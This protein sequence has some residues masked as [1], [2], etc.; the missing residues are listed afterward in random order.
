MKWLA[1]LFRFGPSSDEPAAPGKSPHYAD[2][3]Q[4]PRTR[5]QIAVVHIKTGNALLGEGRFDEAAQQYRQ[6]IL[7]D[8]M[9]VGAHINLGF[10]LVQLGQL[11]EALAP[12]RQALAL[13]P[14]SHDAHYLIGTVLLSQHAFTT[15]I[16][17]L[18][19]TIAL[20][21]DLLVAYRDL[22]KALHEIGQHARAKTVLRAG[23]AVD[24]Q[25]ADLHYFLG[26]IALHQMELDEALTSYDRALAI[27]PD[28]AAVHNNKAQALLDLCEFGSA[29][30]AA[31]K[32]LALDPSM[33]AARSNLLMILSSDGHCSPEDYL[34]EA[35]LYG[36][37][38]MAQKG[39]VTASRAAV[40]H[41]QP[42]EAARPLRIGFVS[43]DLHN[44]PVGFFLDNVMAFW[45]CSLGT[46]AIAY[47][48]HPS[49]DELTVRLQA[50]FSA[51]RDLSIMG[52]EA[53]ARQI[54]SDCIDVLVDLSGHTAENR[55]PLFARRPAPVQ[56]SWLG[57]WASTGL[58]T[59]D[60]LLADP[61]SIPPDQRGHFTESIWYL[62]DTRLC[63]TPPAGAGVPPVSDLPARDAGY[64]TFGSF[65]R[66][67]KLNDDV[68]ALWA[69][70]MQAVP[71]S[72]LRLQSKQMQDR[73]ARA[74]L[75]QR[76]RVAGID[77]QRV[78]LVE[79]STRLEY[80]AAHA[81]VDILL[82]T[83]PHT[84]ATTTCEALW[85]GVP[86]LTLA[87]TTML[88]RQGA[89]LLSCAGLAEWVARDQD[90]YVALAVRHAC[91]LD[92]LGRLRA[93]LREQVSTSPVFDAARFTANLQTA[94]RELSR[95][96]T[97]R[98]MP[99]QGG[100]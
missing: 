89:S 49:H 15:A 85:M 57:Y 76:L 3:A 17:H 36:E 65:Q 46:E 13:D 9:H 6:A 1:H 73:T 33:H 7:V 79:A 41:A 67:T 40:N 71:E 83:F 16:A 19:Q 8:V 10:T 2:R 38:L 91:D 51:W 32:A 25:F 100:A 44:H 77:A 72:R 26:N 58:P 93:S 69:R 62:P 22:G 34:V 42:R 29:A 75:L 80:L 54:E 63:F 86:T 50:R 66:L 60:W 56:V 55:L 21:P 27:Q 31:R 12:L 84:G 90:D 24:S 98:A 18:E 82:D 45:D 92:A 11:A 53:A 95:E 23:L 4:P 96:S 37:L 39:S 52:D 68:L 30:A 28:Y 5:E 35:R 43:G 81:E 97:R 59:I 88:A 47:S 14:T 70:V 74:H 61:I 99:R 64:I 20:K 78:Q 94:L 87:G 48:N